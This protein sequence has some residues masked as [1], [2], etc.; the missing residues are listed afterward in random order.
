MAKN[1]QCVRKFNRAVAVRIADKV[2]QAEIGINMKVTPNII[3]VF[4]PTVKNITVVHGQRRFNG[5]K[6]VVYVLLRKDF[7]RYS[8]LK[9]VRSGSSS[10]ENG[11]TRISVNVLVRLVR[12]ELAVT[13]ALSS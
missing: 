2:R 3:K 7:A 4:R 5:G 6:T 11:Q 1:A 9:Y 12:E 8:V 13:I 10:I